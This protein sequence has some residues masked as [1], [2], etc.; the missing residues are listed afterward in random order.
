MTFSGLAITSS[1][2]RLASRATGGRAA[3]VI[4]DMVGADYTPRNVQCLAVEGRLVQIAFLRGS[5][6]ELDKLFRRNFF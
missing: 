3:D 2:M 5:K 4:L 6:V 1:A